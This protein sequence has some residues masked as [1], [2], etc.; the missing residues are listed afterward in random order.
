[1]PNWILVVDFGSQ[2]TQLIA[3]RIREKNIYCEL[4]PYT[5]LT[6]TLLNK[7]RPSGII[8]SGSPASVNDPQAPLVSEK[9]FFE[10]IPILGICY[11]MQ[12]I[13]KAF[14]GLVKKTSKREYGDTIIQ[15]INN[16]SINPNRW[17]I[18]SNQNVWMSHGDSL[19]NLPEQFDSFIKSTDNN[20]VGITNENKKIFGLQFH[21]EVFHTKDGNLII[22]KFIIDVCKCKQTWTMKTFKNDAINSL[23]QTIK[24]KK[25]LCA[26]SG[27]VDSSVTALLLNQ[28]IG[29]QL[30]CV[31]VDHGLLR[32]NEKEEICKFF[33][34]KKNLNFSCVDS[35]K[36]FLEILK[37]VTDPEIKR[38]LIGSEFIKV[39]EKEAKKYRDI[40]FLAQGTL[41]P[42]I[43]E[44]RSVLGGPSVTIKSHH[45]VGGLPEKMNL[46]LVEPLK[47]LFKDEVRVLGKELGLDDHIRNRH[48]FPGPGLAIRVI[49]KVTKERLTILREADK[50]YMDLL[51]KENLYDEIWQAFC[52][53]LPVKT[54]G[55]MG[56]SRSYENVCA[57]RA[58][59]STDGM[60]ADI[61]SF[62]HN[63]LKKVS[64]SIIN[65]VEGINRVVYDTTSKPPGT[66]EWE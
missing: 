2:V 51:K 15:I 66:I 18:N 57:L 10:N 21:P 17:H 20:Y 64:T 39:F 48:P 24:K 22:Q 6:L 25:V 29:S 27:G 58:V 55:V 45:N 3:R 32:K 19:S 50:I 52:V 46:E 8:L 62:D 60:T 28:A 42:D 38:K 35:S 44:S 1:M 54:V 33:Q 47:S 56:D 34:S 40:K 65:Q 13:A 37:N 16:S 30:Q 5:K 31:F 49:G 7:N 14:G 36:Q 43:I 26:L 11:G 4:I 41:Y 53:L 63:F 23:K 9:I 61:Y 59:T 12:L